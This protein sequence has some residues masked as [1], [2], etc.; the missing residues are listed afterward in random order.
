MYKV[1]HSIGPH[2]PMLRSPR[3]RYRQ[4]Q[5]GTEPCDIHMAVKSKTVRSLWDGQRTL[6]PIGRRWK[7]MRS[8]S[9]T[10]GQGPL[11]RAHL[12][13]IPRPLFTVHPTEAYVGPSSRT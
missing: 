13:T 6:V 11:L 3:D 2:S 12:V 8:R 4:G 10:G 9:V 5:S 7:S 1:H